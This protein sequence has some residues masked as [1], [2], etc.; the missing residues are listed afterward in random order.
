MI[1]NKKKFLRNKK[2]FKVQEQLKLINKRQRFKNFSHKNKFNFKDKLQ[3]L[4][5]IR[6]QRKQIFKEVFKYKRKLKNKSDLGLNKINR[7]KMRRFVKNHF[8]MMKRKKRKV[9][10]F[11][12]KSS[13]GLRVFSKYKRKKNKYLKKL[14]KLHL[15]FVRKMLKYIRIRKKQGRISN[16]NEIKIFF[17]TRKTIKI[18]RD[19]S[20]LILQSRL[21]F[22]LVYI[23]M[24][25]SFFHKYLGSLFVYKN[26]YKSRSFK[27]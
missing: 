12:R 24:F 16:F 3:L 25:S 14:R 17:S 7:L 15:R 21:V 27:L 23:R 13:G 11:K 4:K 20:F 6:I 10:W 18:V 5:K 2:S 8:K 26:I 22:N 9:L 1:K 19:K